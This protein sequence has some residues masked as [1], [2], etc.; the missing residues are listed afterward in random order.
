MD[1]WFHPPS[2]QR[3]ASRNARP[4]ATR[5]PS[6]DPPPSRPSFSRAR[7]EI[8]VG[9]THAAVPVNHGQPSNAGDSP[10]R[11][12]A[13]FDGAP[14]SRH[15]SGPGPPQAAI[16]RAATRRAQSATCSP[17]PIRAGRAL[18]RTVD[19][20]PA[21]G[22]HAGPPRSRPDHRLPRR[23]EHNRLVPYRSRRRDN[24]NRHQNF[25]G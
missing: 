16:W 19:I 23:E 13:L 5:P 22:P 3:R 25:G 20:G 24:P 10:S 21:R 17:R 11:I 8:A 7:M 6:S 1:P 9:M 12:H 4:C 15:A 2:L 14:N 18:H